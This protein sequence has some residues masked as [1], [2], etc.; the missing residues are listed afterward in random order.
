M[1]SAALVLLAAEEH[2]W[3]EWYGFDSVAA[4]MGLAA[5]VLPADEVCHWSEW[6]EFDS[7]AARMGSAVSVELSAEEHRPASKWCDSGWQAAAV[8]EWNA[9]ELVACLRSEQVHV[10]TA[11]LSPCGMAA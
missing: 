6:C 4:R 1:G 8:F 3:L 11:V 2:H 5:L 7:L 9:A 10:S